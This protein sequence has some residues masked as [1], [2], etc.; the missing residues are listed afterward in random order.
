MLVSG[1]GLSMAAPS[2]L[3]SARA[4]AE[5]CFDKYVVAIDPYCDRALRGNLEAFA[6]HFVPLGT[7][8]PVFIGE[9]VPWNLFIQQ[10]NPGHTAIADFL[11]TRAAVAALSS[12]Y[13]FLIERCAWDY[14]AE[15]HA[16]L[17][18]DQATV[19]STRHG[20]LLKFHGC[21]NLDPEET[22]WTKLQLNE[23]IIAS[24]IEK[25]RVWM[26]AN[27]REKDLLAVG[28]WT[29]WAYLNEVIGNA[30]T[31]VTPLSVT[32]VDMAT[33]QQLQDKAP[34]L[35]NLA[36]AE[37]VTFTHVQQDGAQFLDE[38]RRAY[39]RS[40]LRK[41]IRAGVGVFEAETGM[42][43]DP[44]W[45]EVP[46][47]G[48]QVLYDLRRDAEGVPHTLPA[49]QKSPLVSEPLGLFHLLL[50]RA[51]ATQTL[52]GYSYSGQTIRVVNGANAVLSMMAARYA[53]PPSLPVAAITA[54]IGA[55]NLGLPDDIVRTGT[56]GDIV[57][58]ATASRWLD[59]AGAREALGL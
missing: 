9:L 57:R 23:P 22:V 13:D 35:W 46:D 4:V 1:A 24:R 44:Q 39:S 40:F 38:L 42:P 5:A 43:C 28:F 26:A 12:N 48:S 25:S 17:D 41:V 10:P 19:Q 51:G 45:L 53:E 7:F 3:P 59:F 30:L 8:R 56:P 15:F 21:Q 29:D 2:N 34:D 27:L 6:G 52:E 20:P 49:R 54:A 18:G 32:V 33:A 36:H 50:R 31:G 11:L 58:P 14:G 55:I 16:S 37:H 47:H